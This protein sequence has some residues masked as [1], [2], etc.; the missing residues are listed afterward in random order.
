[1]SPRDRLQQDT[2]FWERA[3][4]IPMNESR[5]G[6]GQPLLHRGHVEERNEQGT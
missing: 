1:M 5:P 3:T 4:Y 2:G 6:V